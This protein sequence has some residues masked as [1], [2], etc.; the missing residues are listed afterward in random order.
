MHPFD[1]VPAIKALSGEGYMAHESLSYS[2]K[3]SL[4]KRI[5]V[6]FTS[7]PLDARDR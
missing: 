5:S 7:S 3:Y 6:C 4:T 1:P 2:A